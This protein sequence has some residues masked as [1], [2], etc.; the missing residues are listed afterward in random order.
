MK[1]ILALAILAAAIGAQA[2]LAVQVNWTSP[3]AAATVTANASGT[4]TV[5][6]ILAYVYHTP[7]TITAGVASCPAFNA[8]AWTLD[9][10]TPVSVTSSAANAG[11]FLDTNVTVL[12][13]DC[14]AVTNAF[15]AGGG[16]SAAA[17]SV[18]VT[19]LVMG[20]A[21]AP[22]GVTAVPVP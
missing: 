16:A 21:A 1:L 5:G 8:S 3:S 22:V 6:P 9:T 12:A 19:V 20:S 18:P 14:F 13:V 17:V 10:A 2:Q 7:A 4:E 15:A 11:S